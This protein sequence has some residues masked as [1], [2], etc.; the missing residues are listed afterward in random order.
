[1]KWLEIIE[2]NSGD[3]KPKFIEK[4]LES[5]IEKLKNESDQ[6]QIKV[7]SRVAEEIELSI[8]LHHKSKNINKNGSPLGLKL[9]SALKKA[10]FVNHSIWV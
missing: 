4:D 2:F 6:E 10:G 5:L 9:S 7:Y 8:H 1:M 3:R